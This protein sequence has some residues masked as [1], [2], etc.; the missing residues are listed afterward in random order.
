MGPGP[1]AALGIANFVSLSFPAVGSPI[2]KW[3]GH[4]WLD[5]NRKKRNGVEVNTKIE[6]FYSQSKR[7]K[8]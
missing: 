5:L 8:I 4:C 7:A 6:V 2:P 3:L 1:V